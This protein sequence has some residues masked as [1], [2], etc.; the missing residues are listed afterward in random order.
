MSFEWKDYQEEVARFFRDLGLNAKTDVTVQGA[1][2]RHDADVLVELDYKGISIRWVIE[3]KCWKRS[4]TKETVLALRTIVN[5]VGADRGFIM[6]ESGYQKG[7]R[8]AAYLSNIQLTSLGDLRETC[9]QEL[10][11]T[12]VRALY[13]RSIELG[14]RYWALSK[15]TRIKHGL[16][17]DTYEIPAYSANTVLEASRMALVGA[18]F[19]GFPVR[20]NELAAALGD[21]GFRWEAIDGD[22]IFENPAALADYVSDKLDEIDG[23]LRKAEA[24]R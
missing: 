19:H 1:R 24:D 13:L 14:E 2:T 10:A 8:E 11:M 22:V 4:V 20:Y 5:D 17:N 15:E 9:A 7:A 23:L 18:I 21:H 16:R 3:C 12:R 6:A